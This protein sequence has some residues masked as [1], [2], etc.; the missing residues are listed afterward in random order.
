M[1]SPIQESYEV[2]VLHKLKLS[3]DE[4]NDY[5]SIEY[6]SSIDSFESFSYILV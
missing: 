5:I 2:I 1:F 3:L 6:R 4:I